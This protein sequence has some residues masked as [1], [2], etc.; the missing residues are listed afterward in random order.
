MHISA[1][2]GYGE[3]NEELFQ[4]VPPDNIPEEAREVGKILYGQ[5]PGGQPFPVRVHE[6]R[7]EVIVLDLNHPLA[8]QA[9]SFDIRVVSVE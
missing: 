5:G 6:I 3:I 8:G 2:D 4:E 1:A 7:E 9:L